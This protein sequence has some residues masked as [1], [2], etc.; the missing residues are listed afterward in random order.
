M[1]YR[2]IRAFLLLLIFSLLT[3][4]QQPFSPPSGR[5]RTFDAQHYIIRSRLDLDKKQIVGQ[6]TVRL[7]PLAD[8]FK[9]FELDAV[10]M[11]IRSVSLDEAGN[12]PLKF[13]YVSDRI[14]ITLDREYSTSETVSVT[15]NYTTA[16]RAKKGVQFIDEQRDRTAKKS[17]INPRQVWTQGQPQDSR[18]WFPSYDYPDDKVTSEQF[19]TAPPDE[20]VVSNGELAGSTRNFDGTVTW[21][22]KTSTPHS[23]YLTS[24][25]AGNYVKKDAKYGQIPLGYY[26]YPETEK[27]VPLAFG[28]TAAMMEIFETMTG[29][30]YPYNK[31]DQIMIAQFDSA[32]MENL[33]ATTL[34]DAEVFG[35]EVAT[36]RPYVDDLVAHEI[37]HSWFGNLV[38]CKTWSHL[39]LNEGFAT[40]M[41]AVFREHTGNRNTYL[42]RVRDDARK[43]FGSELSNKRRHPLVDKYDKPDELFDTTVY[44]KGG[45][46]LYQLREAVGDEAF[47]KAVN[48]YLNRHKFD[49]V[50]TADLQKVMEEVSEKNLDWFFNQWVYGSGF[51]ELSLTSSYDAKAKKVTLTVE[52][53]QKKRADMVEAFTLPV[54]I[55]VDT[56][57]GPV[58]KSVKIDKIKQTFT[59]PVKAAPEKI[60]FDK[61]EKIMLRR[62]Q[63]AGTVKIELPPMPWQ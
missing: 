15:V 23:T 8:G 36:L 45:V 40:F 28:K 44:Q 38:T 50:E 61:A 16:P 26:V 57:S 59:I 52:Q 18:H 2:S 46:V 60:L 35:A 1:F 12:A 30:K 22:Y 39:W 53:K 63:T 58:K 41:V 62:I 14:F 13:G 6:T 55:E 31:Y 42:L 27:L 17:L 20:V 43:Y 51:P 47:W 49:N 25:V 32:G 33:T 48:I 21:H 37:A 3:V 10:G 11:D 34:L 54:D 19:I 56:A 9:A 24:F 29:V 7:K 4:A 5:V